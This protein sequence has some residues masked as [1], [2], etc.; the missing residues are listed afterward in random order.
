MSPRPL[1]LFGSALFVAAALCTG[2]VSVNRIYPQHTLLFD[3]DGV[4]S[5]IAKDAGPAA[6][7]CD[8]PAAVHGDQDHCLRAMSP[9]QYDAYLDGLFAGYDAWAKARGPRAEPATLAIYIP[10]GVQD[11]NATLNAEDRLIQGKDL[12]RDDYLIEIHWSAGL[13]ESMI[14]HW[15]R[16]SNGARFNTDRDRYRAGPKGIWRNDPDSLILR[17]ISQFVIPPFRVLDDLRKGTVEIFDTLW[18]DLDAVGNSQQWWNDHFG[19]EAALNLQ[20]ALDERL[21]DCLPGQA[22]P[23]VAC[24]QA[25]QAAR[26]LG[27]TGDSQAFLEQEWDWLLGI[28]A[29]PFVGA[30][31]LLLRE[32]GAGA[33][34]MMRRHADR[35]FVQDEADNAFHYYRMDLRSGTPVQRTYYDLAGLGDGPLGVFLRRLGAFQATHPDV[36]TDLYAHSM[37]ALVADEMLRRSWAVQS[38]P[39]C[40]VSAQN[41]RV[42]LRFDRIAYLAPADSIQG[43]QDSVWPYLDAHN[44]LDGRPRTLFYNVMLNYL[45]EDRE[46]HWFSFFP[47]AGAPWSWIPL[48]GWSPIPVWEQGSPLAWIDNHIASPQGSLDRTLGRASNL[49]YYV[50]SIPAP[51]LDQIRL[52]SFRG[53]RDSL[54]VLDPDG[55]TETVAAPQTDEEAGQVP[56]WKDGFYAGL[57]EPCL[58]GDGFY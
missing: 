32:G 13:W 11:Y 35:L 56:F 47:D 20:P 45:S 55:R 2:C 26:L 14:D 21:R 12:G 58:K 9:D 3:L 31:S 16:V 36:K 7:G 51:L 19:E 49:A 44:G 23:T 18:I 57:D 41:P 39:L 15:F 30:E 28:Y 43:W 46:R 29:L 4:P 22:S 10:G 33:F 54:S 53:G 5:T 48:V 17:P 50:D 25:H 38:D 42:G 37:G 27:G 24:A 34:A 40:P 1:S 52:R 6:P 8:A